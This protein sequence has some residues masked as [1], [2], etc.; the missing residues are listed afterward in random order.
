MVHT[1]GKVK[2]HAAEEPVS[3]CKE[4]FLEDTS[5]VK[6]GRR[7]RGRKGGSEDKK[8]ERVVWCMMETAF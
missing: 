5:K 4:N 6:R 3:V 8:R 2:N 7:G 1:K